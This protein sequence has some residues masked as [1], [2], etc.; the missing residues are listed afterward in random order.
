MSSSWIFD[1]LVHE[2]EEV[3]LGLRELF[4]GVVVVQI[5]SR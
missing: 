4:L 3:P 2:A 5:C 1:V